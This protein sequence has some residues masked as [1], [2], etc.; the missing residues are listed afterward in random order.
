M[1][2]VLKKQKTRILKVRV[3][4]HWT[5]LHFLKH[6][7]GAGS[8]NRTGTL[9]PARDF[10]SRASTYSAIP[11]TRDALSLIYRNPASFSPDILF[12]A[13]AGRRMIQLCTELS[14]RAMM[15]W[16]SQMTGAFGSDISWNISGPVP[17]STSELR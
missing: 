11:A 10:E 8:R 17:S 3:A 9:F 5:L 7:L 4:G 1:P 15:S 2:K 13:F 16:F 14:W 12:S 6:V